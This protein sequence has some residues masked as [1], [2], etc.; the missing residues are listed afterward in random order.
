MSPTVLKS[1]YFSLAHPH[2]IYVIEIHANTYSK[3][4]DPLIKINPGNTKLFWST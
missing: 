2:F 1:V 3:Y 4:V